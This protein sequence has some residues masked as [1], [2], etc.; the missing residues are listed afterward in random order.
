MIKYFE[1]MTD[2]R[3]KGKT[4]HNLFEIVIMTV[5]VVIAACT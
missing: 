3:Q 2:N 5:I 4:E 1:K